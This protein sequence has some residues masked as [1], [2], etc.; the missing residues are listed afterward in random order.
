MVKRGQVY[1]AQLNPIV[2]HEQAGHRPVLV[3]SEER[4][5]ATMKLAL[6]VPLTSREKWPVPL[7][8]DVGLVAGKRAWALPGQ[9]RTLSVERLVQS[10]A[11]DSVLPSAVEQCLDAMLQICGRR[12]KAPRK[13]DNDG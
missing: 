5:G 4:Y 11:L 6:V 7:Q 3:L 8:V 9:I 1:W 2:G 12:P 10:K 13:A